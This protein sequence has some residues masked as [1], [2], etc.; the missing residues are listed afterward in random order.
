MKIHIG[1]YLMLMLY[2]LLKP[3]SRKKLY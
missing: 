3:M 1:N 2:L